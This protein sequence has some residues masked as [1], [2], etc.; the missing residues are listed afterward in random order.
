MT[1]SFLVTIEVAVTHTG[2][3][4]EPWMEVD[5]GDRVQLP[6]ATAR[7]RT[8]E[9]GVDVGADVFGCSGV[10]QVPVTIGLERLGRTEEIQVDLSVVDAGAPE[11]GSIFAVDPRDGDLLDISSPI[12]EDSPP[13]SVSVVD[14]PTI[15]FV[16]HDVYAAIGQG[17]QAFVASCPSGTDPSNAQASSAC[18]LLPTSVEPL[19]DNDWMHTVASAPLGPLG[20]DAALAGTDRV[21]Y[22]VVENHACG[23]WF[24]F[25][26]FDREPL[27][28]D[29]DCDGDGVAPPDDCD[30]LD[31][32]VA[33]GIPDTWYD[34]VDTD[35]S[36][37]SDLDQDGDGADAIG[38]GGDDCD[39]TDPARVPG[40]LEICD[41][42]D[43]D[44]DGQLAVGQA[45]RMSGWT[46]TNFSS[47]QAAL[48]AAVDGDTIAVCD[49][50]Y[51]GPFVVDDAIA[52]T[53][54][55]L[56]PARTTLEG[57]GPGESVVRVGDPGDAH[58]V[59]IAGFTIGG[60]VGASD[61]GGIDGRGAATLTLE[62]VAVV[63]NDAAR[64]GGLA[65]AGEVVLRRVEV[66]SNT[67][68]AGGGI[69]AEDGATLTLEDTVVQGN[70][71]SDSGGGLFVVG[72]LTLSGT[73]TIETNHADFN[74]GGLYA[75]GDG[76][77]LALTGVMFSGNEAELAGGGGIF[78]QSTGAAPIAITLDDVLL[79]ANDAFT[80]GAIAVAFATLETG[81][82]ELDG[83]TAA[84][85]GAIHAGGSSVVQLGALGGAAALSANDAGSW[86]GG[87]YVE[88]DASSLFAVDA[89]F[90]GNTAGDGAAI[91]TAGG[92]VDL[93]G[94]TLTANVADD[95]GGAIRVGGGATVFLRGAIVV[96]GNVASGQDQAAYLTE[97]LLVG[98][99]GVEVS[100][101]IVNSQ[102]VFVPFECFEISDADNWLDECDG[103]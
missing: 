84:I 86:G 10:C 33:P 43:N 46:V 101:P 90:D 30:D 34:G 19:D 71:A 63:D 23:E 40:A 57:G 49:G 60:G 7:G 28:V 11:L 81:D 26:F 18:T 99:D 100:D 37:G 91:D 45:T 1:A 102:G 78:A 42:R 72:S 12:T 65:L 98:C 95:E 17:G 36:G 6:P 21:L 4:F 53:S 29:P 8:V 22:A 92:A 56:D 68:I 54:G 85:G 82:V 89:V 41:G 5:G 80:G 66:S 58:E 47:V 93:T 77:S 14:W 27:F 48:D 103:C 52:F 25:W 69:V 75:E 76:A 20:C 32:A 96:D 55:S 16:L 51:I 67:A 2:G 38:Y 50:T 3:T 15:G 61:G 64:G 59:T 79:T 24:T 83:N 44:C 62:D 87:A 70:T 35:C 88:D 13:G 31:P 97:G 94:G 39:D 9:L 74:G 73:G